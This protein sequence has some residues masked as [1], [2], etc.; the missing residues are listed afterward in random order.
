MAVAIKSGGTRPRNELFYGAGPRTD[1][2]KWNWCHL[3]RD[4]IDDIYTD[5]GGMVTR[6]ISDQANSF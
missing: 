1:Y 6:I 4:V 2:D 5:W 3:R